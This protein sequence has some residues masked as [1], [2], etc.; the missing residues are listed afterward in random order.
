MMGSLSGDSFGVRGEISA[1]ETVVFGV[2][3]GLAHYYTQSAEVSDLTD[4]DINHAR[5]IGILKHFAEDVC[6][7]ILF[8]VLLPLNF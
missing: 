1:A 4:V 5:D 6:P 7:W 3:R 8:H 2:V